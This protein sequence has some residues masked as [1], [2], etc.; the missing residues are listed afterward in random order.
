MLHLIFAVLIFVAK[1]VACKVQFTSF[2][3]IINVNDVFFKHS[4]YLSLKTM[5]LWDSQL[6]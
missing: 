6:L 4:M 3:V 2:L 5:V 1:L